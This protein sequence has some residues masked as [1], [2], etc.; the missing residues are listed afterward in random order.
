[1]ADK[2]RTFHFRTIQQVAGAAPY[3]TKA[4]IRLP[5]CGRFAQGFCIASRC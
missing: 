2:R 1:M 3:S 5:K 4:L